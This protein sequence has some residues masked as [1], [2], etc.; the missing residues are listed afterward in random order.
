MCR[1]LKEPAWE[2]KEEM[3]LAE[4]PPSIFAHVQSH[5]GVTKPFCFDICYDPPEGD[6]RR[7][8]VMLK[9]KAKRGNSSEW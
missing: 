1:Q 6:R 3:G 5:T 7:N 4:S 8:K 9:T 2:T